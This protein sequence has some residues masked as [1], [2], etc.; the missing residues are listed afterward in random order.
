M[1]HKSPFKRHRSPRDNKLCPARWYL[2]YPLSYQDVVDLP[3][4][5]GVLVD[6][7]PVFC[8]VRKL[9][10]ELTKRAENFCAERNFDWR[11]DGTYMRVGRKWRYLWHAIDAN[12]QMVDLRLAAR[13]ASIA[14]RAI[15]RKAIERVRLLR[16]IAICTDKDERYRHI[17]REISHR[18]DPHCD[19]IQ[20]IDRK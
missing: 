4:E 9:G 12:G 15:L 18:Y 5:C 3:A 14:A 16:P 8:W 2:R 6:R 17:I 19:R 1:P 20:R 10:P 7:S 11:V 13:R